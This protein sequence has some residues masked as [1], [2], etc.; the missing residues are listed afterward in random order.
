MLCTVVITL[1]LPGN[2]IQIL[3]HWM[4]IEGWYRN[5]D[6]YYTYRFKPLMKRF[7]RVMHWVISA[8]QISALQE[9]CISYGNHCR[10]LVQAHLAVDDRYPNVNYLRVTNL[11]VLMIKKGFK[12]KAISFEWGTLM[13]VTNLPKA[14]QTFKIESQR[15]SKALL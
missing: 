10:M 15:A 3:R 4:F 14:F 2:Y 5:I 12:Y 6:W 7:A 8:L 1:H 9:C 13:S 11:P